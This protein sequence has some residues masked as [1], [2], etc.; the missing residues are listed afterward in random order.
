M[1]FGE[2]TLLLDVKPTTTRSKD[3]FPIKEFANDYWNFD[4]EYE[5]SLDINDQLAKITNVFLDKGEVL[6]G[7]CDKFNA[8]CGFVIVVNV[9]NGEFPAM[10]FN[11][12]FIQFAASI[13]AEVGFDPY[14]YSDCE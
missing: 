7:I 14:F 2:I 9:E 1:N 12:N 11:T 3:T 8:K 5:N 4:T 10:Y 13:N 6:N